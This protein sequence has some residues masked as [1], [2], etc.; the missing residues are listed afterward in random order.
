MRERPSVKL[1]EQ[2]LDITLRPTIATTKREP[3]RLRLLFRQVTRKL[4]RQL[5][6]T[7][8]QL[9]TFQISATVKAKAAVATASETAVAATAHAMAVVAADADPAVYLA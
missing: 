3:R 6:A 5:A 9:V 4:H 8:V 2:R 7:K 1:T